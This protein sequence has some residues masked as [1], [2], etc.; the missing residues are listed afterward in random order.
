MAT[1]STKASS[2]EALEEEV[3]EVWAKLQTENHI[4]PLTFKGLTFNEPTKAQIDAWRAAKT[5]EEGERALFGDL[6]DAVHELFDPLPQHIWENFN[7]LY[8]K[9]MFGTS[10]DDALKG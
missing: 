8:L 10:G 7:V 4:P 3:D 6:Y 9:H 5:V 1:R 2:T